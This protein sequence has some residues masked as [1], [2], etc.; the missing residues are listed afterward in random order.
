MRQ[1]GV[2]IAFIVMLSG[3]QGSPGHGNM[4]SSG[5]NGTGGQLYVST[6]NSIL[7]FIN[8]ENIS[9]NVAPAS[10]L[11]ALILYFRRRNTSSSML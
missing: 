8:A 5:I 2:A 6:P 1:A 7:H 11:A 10:V 4:L 9:G 3:C